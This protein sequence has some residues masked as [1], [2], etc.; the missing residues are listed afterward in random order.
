MKKLLVLL[1]FTVAAFSANAQTEQLN[2]NH[3]ELKIKLQSNPSDLEILQQFATTCYDLYKNTKKEEYASAYFTSA[4]AIIKDEK[5]T[6]V[7]FS[8]IITEALQFIDDFSKWEDGVV[9][10]ESSSTAIER[11]TLNENSLIQKRKA[12]TNLL[13]KYRGKLA[14]ENPN[15]LLSSEKYLNDISQKIINEPWNEDNY[16]K[17]IEIYNYTQQKDKV[18]ADKKAIA[19]IK[20]NRYEKLAYLELKDVFREGKSHS[21]IK[22]LLTKQL[23]KNNTEVSGLLAQNLSSNESATYKSKINELKI[24]IENVLIN[25]PITH[26]ETHYKKLV[27][28]KIEFAKEENS[29]AQ[30]ILKGTDNDI[31]TYKF[32]EARN[33]SYNFGGEAYSYADAIKIVKDNSVYFKEYESLLYELESKEKEARDN[34]DMYYKESFNMELGRASPQNKPKE[35]SQNQKGTSGRFIEA[36]KEY[37]SFIDGVNSALKLYKSNQSKDNKTSL[38]NELNKAKS[39]NNEILRILESSDGS[40]SSSEISQYKE[41]AKRKETELNDFYDKLDSGNI[42][43]LE[44][45]LIGLT[46][47]LK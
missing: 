39:K 7:I 44:A 45:I 6:E 5:L 47:G 41:M 3:E 18:A 38:R 9:I 19:I 43:L 13:E 30:N 37:M 14:I 29:K 33:A 1:L 28:K 21:K 40:L 46:R 24:K 16:E 25:L 17:R 20:F 8:K 15:A 32:N 26:N 35:G 42:S 36:V 27:E 10:L 11:I 23:P 22:E 31:Y 12:C 2:K 4:N 34:S